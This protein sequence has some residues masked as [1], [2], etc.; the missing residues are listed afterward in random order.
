MSASN[1]AKTQ[2]DRGHE[3]SGD[4]LVRSQLEN[5]GIRNCRICWNESA[6]ARRR[7]NSRLRICPK[8]RGPLTRRRGGWKVCI[9]CTELRKLA[10]EMIADGT[11]P[12]LDNE[13][14]VVAQMRLKYQPLIRAT[15]RKA[16]IE[17]L[18]TYSGREISRN[19]EKDK[20]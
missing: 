17:E 12:S 16:Q 4:N 8:C 14:K 6:R 18:P 7:R 1:R 20:C 11:M 9:K 3:L 5:A 13:I 15:C 2:C 19:C 10:A